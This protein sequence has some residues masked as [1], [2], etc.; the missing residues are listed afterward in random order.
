MYQLRSQYRSPS[1]KG[2]TWPV[3][4]ATAAVVVAADLFR[5]L[6]PTGCQSPPLSPLD[7]EA[8]VPHVAV[9]DDVVF[10]LEPLPTALHDLGT[11]ARLDQIAPA[12]H[13]ATNEP[14]GDVGVDRR[15]GIERGLPSAQRPGAG[16][17]LSSGEE[18]DQNDRL[19]ETPRDLADCS[20]LAFAEGSGLLVGQLRQLGLELR[21]QAAGTVSNLDQRLRR[22]RLEPWRQLP[23]PLGPRP[24]GLEVREYCL[25]LLDRKSTR[26]NSSH[27]TISY[28]VFCLKK[29]KE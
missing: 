9:L 26:L 1:M 7:V 25:E 6:A 20:R 17:V 3:A 14:A 2:G 5:G 4:T 16:L 8:D 28:A 11:R 10:A 15:R 13:L 12:N 24:L 22:Q 21:V 29:K 27:R 19:E 18:R 23:G